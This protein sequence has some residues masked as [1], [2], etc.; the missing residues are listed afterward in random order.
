[1]KQVPGLGRAGLVSSLRE[2]APPPRDGQ[3]LRVA[4]PSEV[5]APEQG[6]GKA[7]SH[8]HMH[9]Q[10]HRGTKAP[11]PPSSQ[12]RPSCPCRPPAKPSWEARGEG[13]GG[14][15]APSPAAG[16][17]GAL[18]GVGRRGGWT[19]PCGLYTQRVGRK[20]P[21]PR[22]DVCR[23]P[24]CCMGVAAGRRRCAGPTRLLGRVLGDERHF[25]GRARQKGEQARSHGD[26]A[27][28]ASCWLR[29]IAGL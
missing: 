14:A 6:L 23:V 10:K 15:E 25:P 12:P 29:S 19:A 27:C 13:P 8:G 28:L 17:P 16:S 24:A 21:P 20:G 26:F 11:P 7:G 9:P 18:S 4:R 1:M 2:P 5:K 22:P 3:S